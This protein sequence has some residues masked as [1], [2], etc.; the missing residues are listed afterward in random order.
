MDPI[1]PIIEKLRAS[2]LVEAVGF[3]IVLQALELILECIN[4]ENLDKKQILLPDQTVLISID[5][6]AVVNYLQ[7]SEREE[8]SDLMM[9]GAMF[10]FSLKKMVWRKE[11]MQS[12]FPKPRGAKSKVPKTLYDTNLKLEIV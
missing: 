5:R 12:W 9:G 11:I 3:P 8:F 6:Q 10:E 1:H 2:G 7:I 4:H